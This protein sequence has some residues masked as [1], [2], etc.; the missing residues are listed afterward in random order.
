MQSQL[1]AAFHKE[2]AAE[3]HTRLQY[4][5]SP[6]H[7]I[8]A[9]YPVISQLGR[10]AGFQREDDS[11]TKLDKLDAL[12]PRTATAPEEAALLADLLSLPTDRYPP[13]NLSPQ[14]RKDKTLAALVRQLEALT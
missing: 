1:V 3:P 10:A 9:L 4:F 11:K 2:I 8:S 13:L 7:Q 5:F 6:C 12:L 14:Q